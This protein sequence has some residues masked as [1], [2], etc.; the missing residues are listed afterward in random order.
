[1]NEG[2]EEE[3]GGGKERNIGEEDRWEEKSIVYNMYNV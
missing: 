3:R 2:E 1:M